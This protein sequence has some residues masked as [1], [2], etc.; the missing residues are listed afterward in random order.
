MLNKLFY[1]D[2][3]FDKFGYIGVAMYSS[4]GKI[5]GLSLK[6][7]RFLKSIC[8]YYYKNNEKNTIESLIN[9]KIFIENFPSLEKLRTIINLKLISHIK[10]LSV[11]KIILSIYEHYLK[12]F[13]VPN[14]DKLLNEFIPTA[15]LFY[16]EFPKNDY[17]I[18]YEY[19]KGQ[20]E[21]FD[22]LTKKLG[23]NLYKFASFSLKNITKLK[24]NY[25]NLVEGIDSSKF[26]F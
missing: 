1:L 8:E 20:S 24:E 12:N 16:S 7:E 17:T 9:L 2:G 6:K 23:L 25:K 26:C 5:R 14:Y 21:V 19:L 18:I 22:I 13:D 4:L 10:E 15:E 3:V 11:I